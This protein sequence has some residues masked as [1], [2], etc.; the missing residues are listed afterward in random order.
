MIFALLLPNG[1]QFLPSKCI[2]ALA[3]FFGFLCA[4]LSLS[5]FGYSNWSHD[6]ENGI[7]ITD[8]LFRFSFLVLLLIRLE[9]III[10]RVFDLVPTLFCLFLCC[11]FEVKLS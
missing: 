10:Y 1:I 4:C 3:Q 2:K 9:R 8:F 11:I 5:K 7:I 6:L